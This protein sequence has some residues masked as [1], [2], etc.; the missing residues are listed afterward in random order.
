MSINTYLLIIFCTLSK[1]TSSNII[2]VSL[3]RWKS[4]LFI[5]YCDF[6]LS[7][8]MYYLFVFCTTFSWAFPL[9]STSSLFLLTQP[10]IV[11]IS[12]ELEASC[13]YN[14]CYITSDSPIQEYLSL[15]LS[16]FLEFHSSF[17]T[18]VNWHIYELLVKL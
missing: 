17:F 6:F 4:L 13:Y 3:N 16:Y 15:M 1:E 2:S 5:L 12:L 8:H 14:N 9:V 7:E 10:P 11:P 18:E